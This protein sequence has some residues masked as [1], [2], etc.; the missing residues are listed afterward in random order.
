FTIKRSQLDPE[1]FA[2]PWFAL[3]VT[4]EGYAPDWKYVLN[5]TGK[6]ETTFRLPEDVPIR[7]RILDLNGK[8]VAGATLRL[9]SVAAHANPDAFL[10]GVREGML[11]FGNST[12]WNGLFPGVP[13]VITSDSEGRIQVKGIGRDRVVQFRLEGP[14]IEYSRLRM[15]AREMN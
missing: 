12:T 15:I 2:S 3:M 8:P 13:R 7:G 11:F 5:P 9:E 10:Q 1:A 6:V 14:G 4:A